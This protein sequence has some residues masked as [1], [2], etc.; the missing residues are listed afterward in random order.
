MDP[1][2]ELFVNGLGAGFA[3]S[4]SALALLAMSTISWWLVT[5]ETDVGGDHGL[6]GVVVS[7]GAFLPHVYKIVDLGLV[8]YPLNL[9]RT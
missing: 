3:G 9:K 7:G 8:A 2:S 1:L 5:K 4:R 6:L